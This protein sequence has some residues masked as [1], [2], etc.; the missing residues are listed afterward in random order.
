M[1]SIG[2]YTLQVMKLAGWYNNWLFSHVAPNL[3]G[4]ILEVGAGIGNFTSLLAKKGQVWAID[5]EKDYISDLKKKFGGKVKVGYGDIE[6]D[7]YFFKRHLPAG[8]Q[9]KFETIVCMNVLEHIKDDRKALKNMNKL[10]KKGGRLVLLVPAHSFAYGTLDE[11]LGHFRRYSKKE[12]SEKLEK[13]GLGI[14]KLN[15]LNFLGIWGWFMNA[16]ILNEP[17]LPG[18]QLKIFDVLSRPFLFLEKFI[19]PPFGLSVLVVAKKK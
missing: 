10:L 2:G 13:A 12:L 16:K 7:K 15:F 3:K 9:G 4:K 17:T 18:N 14:E 8:R 5:V 1:S 11:N 6:K 19:E